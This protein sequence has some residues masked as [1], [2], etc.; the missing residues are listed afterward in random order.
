MSENATAFD[1]VLEACQDQHRRIVLGVLTEERRS[2][3]LNELTEAV[4]T[5][6]HRTPPAEAPED[7]LREIRLS[8]YHVHLRK[9]DAE[10]FV[11]YDPVRQLVEPTDRLAQA[12]STLS[13]I[14]AADPSLEAPLEL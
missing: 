13:P 3:T 1:S 10:G 12:Q 2:L 7:V 11:N 6:N 8:L 14:L 4:V 5:H 9:L